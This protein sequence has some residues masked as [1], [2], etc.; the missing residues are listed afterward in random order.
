[1]PTRPLKL[2]VLFLTALVLLACAHSQPLEL[3]PSLAPQGSDSGGW[4]DF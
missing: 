2:L 4:K 3:P 1:M